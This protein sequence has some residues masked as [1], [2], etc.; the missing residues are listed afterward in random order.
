MCFSATASFI[1]SGALAAS[2][3]AIACTPKPGRA[4]P[5]SLFPVFFAVLQFAE[6][7]LWLNHRGF[8]SD[9]F[10]PVG[11]YIFLFIAYVLWPIYVPFSACVL[12]SGRKRRIIILVCQILGLAVGITNLVV[13]INGPVDA[14]VVGHHFAYAINMPE[15]LNAPYVISV[16]VPFLVSSSRRLVIFGAAL[17]VLYA[18]AAVVA[19][20]ATFPSVWC[21]YA[22]ILSV[23]LFFIF[24]TRAKQVWK[25]AVPDATG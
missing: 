14:S 22:A 21:F 18:I 10:K 17:A 11:L 23:F 15:I 16:A 24:R 13:I 25:P 1:A 5:L 12:E 4:L 2:G 3:A 7:L 6:G 19:S 9:T 8:L 20:S